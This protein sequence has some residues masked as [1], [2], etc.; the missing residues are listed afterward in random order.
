[1]ASITLAYVLPLLIFSFVFI[2]SYAL[3]S[4]TRV[5]GD[6]GAMNT[7][8]SFLLSLIFLLTPSASKFT[9][10]AVPWLAVLLV[11]LTFV[12]L[13]LVFVHGK[14][15]D[16]VKNPIVSLIVAG[17]VVMVFIAAAINVFGPLINSIENGPAGGFF[18][19]SVIGVIVLIIVAVVTSRI[20]I[21]AK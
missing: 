4:K 1:M 18:T 15:D 20:L 19:P 17:S 7:T 12:L 2:V 9:V 5:L 6:S 8:V 10:V 13:T 16:T 14:I 3:F 11:V 21:K